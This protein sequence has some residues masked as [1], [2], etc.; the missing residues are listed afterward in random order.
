VSVWGKKIRKLLTNIH[1]AENIPRR[2]L[3]ASVGA[4]PHIL[5]APPFQSND[6]IKQTEGCEIFNLKVYGMRDKSAIRNRFGC[7][8]LDHLMTW[9]SFFGTYLNSKVLINAAA[10]YETAQPKGWIASFFYRRLRF[11]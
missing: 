10:N 8:R 9:T 6:L 1:R 3:S 4:L 7:Q 5:A 11:Q 2:A